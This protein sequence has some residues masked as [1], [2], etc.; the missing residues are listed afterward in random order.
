MSVLIFKGYNSLILQTEDYTDTLPRR[1]FP[2]TLELSLFE[3]LRHMVNVESNNFNVVSF[4]NEYDEG[5][6][7]VMA[8]VTSFAGVPYES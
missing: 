4:P 3:T 6:D 1:H 7:G 2:S 5:D 8:K